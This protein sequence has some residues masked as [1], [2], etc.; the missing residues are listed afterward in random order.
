[1]QNQIN[2]L[3]IINGSTALPEPVPKFWNVVEIN[4]QEAEITMY[5][6]V[7]SRR[8]TD[9]WTGEPVDGLYITPE[10]F[11]EDLALVK[12]K[13]KITVR[14]NS[15]GGDLYTALGI[16]NRLKELAGE[17]VAVIDGIAASAATII[18]MGCKARE[19]GEGALFMIHEALLTLIGNYNHKSL[20]EVNKRLEAANKAAAETYDAATGLGI[21]KI[22]NLMAKETWYTGREAVENGF[23]TKIREGSEASMSMS[24]EKDF[25][26]ING[27]QH[28][29]KGFHNF[30]SGNIPVI[31][32]VQ[33]P[34]PA[35][36]ASVLRVTNKPKGG[37]NNMTAEELRK[38][39]PEAIA[40][41]ELAAKESAKAEAINAERSRLQEIEEIEATVGDPELIQEAKY[42]AKACTAQELALIALKKQ[43]KL[44][45]E[46]IKNSTEDFAA[47]GAA[48]VS[49]TPNTGVPVPEANEKDEAAEQKEL[50]Q[51]IANAG[52]IP[53]EK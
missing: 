47:S 46:H 25:V 24:A 42:G 39:Y 49:T 27:L 38:Q 1:M 32:S 43:A 34:N 33:A 16:C 50:A 2:P 53:A 52:V 51:L 9:W 40:A 14:I 41:I 4:D 19:I 30:P 8:P 31:Q 18:A 23:C 5:G 28:S 13:A 11:L 35:P 17:T 7:V 15:V 45:A 10:G 29:I 12:N 37:N 6:E 44:G 21:E 20:V 26:I 48:N 36:V 3:K 22:R